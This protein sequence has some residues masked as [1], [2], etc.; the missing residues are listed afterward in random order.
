MVLYVYRGSNENLVL[1]AQKS[2]ICELILGNVTLFFS[3]VFIYD[4]EVTPRKW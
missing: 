3:K 1:L 4:R 2:W